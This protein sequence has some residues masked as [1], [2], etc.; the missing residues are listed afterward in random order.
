[1]TSIKFDDISPEELGISQPTENKSL[2]VDTKKQDSSKSSKTPLG[3]LR[4]SSI[5]K[6]SIT[7]INLLIKH[8]DNMP[9]KYVSLWGRSIQIFIE[10]FLDCFKRA[11]LLDNSK[12]QEKREN[13]KLALGYLDSI[14]IYTRIIL[15]DIN[16]HFG[17]DDD[18]RIIISE[19]LGRVE[20]D[21]TKWYNSLK[22]DSTVE[23]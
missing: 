11:F 2:S 18:D 21:L 10:S 16:V 12:I 15:D 17:K 6:N 7:L 8:S 19:L 22:R 1:M 4:S 5:Y 13:I 23:D 9:K 20:S 3:R 14:C